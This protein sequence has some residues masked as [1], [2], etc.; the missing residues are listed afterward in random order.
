[1]SY[2]NGVS[3]TASPTDPHV[4]AVVRS[5][6][7]EIRELLRQRAELMKRIGTVKQTL[8]G[9]AD[10][11]GNSI[12]NQEL[13]ELLDRK[14]VRHSGFTRTCRTILMQSA[15]PLSARQVR[16]QIQRQSPDLLE[17]HQ[18]P[19]ASIT[20]VLSRLVKY[21]EARCTV[22]GPGRRV[23]EWAAEVGGANATV[24]AAESRAAELAPPESE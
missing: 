1:M 24:I 3:I 2:N 20:T 14:T 15:L 7:R 23:W 18:D 22:L 8:T 12:L 9:L 10:L 19:L 5:A 6:E 21:S 11:F 4:E 13:L 16:D 17:R